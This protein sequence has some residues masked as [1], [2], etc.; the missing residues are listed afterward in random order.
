MYADDTS[1]F[2]GFKTTKEQLISAFS[3]V[4]EWLNATSYPRMHS[5]DELN[6]DKYDIRRVK[7]DTKYLGKTMMVD[8]CLTWE[9]HIDYITLKINIGIGIIRR[10]LDDLSQKGSAMYVY[11][12]V[13]LQHS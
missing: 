3:K 13:I 8:D 6:L 4:C 1:R 11:M 2:K 12:H 5:L 9:D 10:E 7:K